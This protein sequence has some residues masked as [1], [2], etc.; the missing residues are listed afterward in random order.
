L[1]G[2][3]RAAAA[4]Q[5]TAKVSLT[6]LGLDV[7]DRLTLDDWRDLGTQIGSGARSMAFVIG[8]WLVYAE[9]S[10][11]RGTF[12][13][14]LPQSQNIPG[15][16]YAEGSRLTGMDVATLANYAY[17]ARNVPRALRNDSLSWEHHKKVTKLKD[18][19]EKRRWLKVAAKAGTNG[20]PVSTRRLARSIEAGR[21]LSI[22]ATPTSTRSARSSASCAGVGGSRP[23]RRKSG[24]PSSGICSRWSISGRNCE[25]V[26]QLLLACSLLPTFRK[27]IADQAVD[28]RW[29]VLKRIL[30]PK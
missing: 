10:N 9:G 20:Q 25:G 8:D 6:P 29:R 19:V 23:P 12:E 1:T 4:I 21:L 28:D 14:Y 11:G 24:T 13:E 3:S 7:L 17:V 22:K 27:S 16:L 26:K 15:W 2:R 5:T 18:D 30:A